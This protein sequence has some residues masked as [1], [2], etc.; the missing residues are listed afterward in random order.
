[1]KL[2]RTRR[3]DALIPTASMADIAFLLIIFFMVT[4]THEVDR[5]SVNLPEAVIRTEAEK[6]AAIVVLLKDRDTGTLAY[7][8]SDGEVMSSV[9]GGP[10]DIYLEAARLTREDPGKQFLLKADGSVPYEKIDELLDQMR[11]G[12]VGQVLL[13]TQQRTSPV[14]G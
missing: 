9:V 2:T 14:S 13:L 11:R 8:F 3:A 5:T 4:T 6:G 12:G 10:E 7:K 1:M